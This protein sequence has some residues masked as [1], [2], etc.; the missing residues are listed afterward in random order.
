MKTFLYILLFPEIM[1]S[2]KSIVWKEPISLTDRLRKLS[3]KLTKGNLIG[4]LF[5][6][7]VSYLASEINYYTGQEA[8]YTKKESALEYKKQDKRVFTEMS[9]ADSLRKYN[10]S[11]PLND[12]AGYDMNDLRK[13]IPQDKLGKYAKYFD[14]DRGKLEEKAKKYLKNS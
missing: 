9:L 10:V 14:M 5:L 12:L 2:K 6:I 11:I 4:G 1:P 13:Y 3:K 7:S 8:S